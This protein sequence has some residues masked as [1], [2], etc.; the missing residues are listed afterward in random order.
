MS[1]CICWTHNVLRTG[2]F[3]FSPVL[4]NIS[5]NSSNV[6]ICVSIIFATNVK[7]RCNEAVRN[8]WNKH[9]YNIPKVYTQLSYLYAIQSSYSCTRSWLGIDGIN[10]YVQALTP[11]HRQTPAPLIRDPTSYREFIGE[12][13]NIQTSTY[14][15]YRQLQATS[16][17]SNVKSPL[18]PRLKSLQLLQDVEMTS[19][20]CNARFKFSSLRRQ[21]SCGMRCHIVLYTVIY[22]CTISNSISSKHWR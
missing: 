12:S 21:P 15:L 14:Q 11:T 3:D 8:L 16:T 5:N 1:L 19:C 4:W 6:D 18:G 20:S 7:L 22:L 9:I 10:Q 17:I 2:V 13:M